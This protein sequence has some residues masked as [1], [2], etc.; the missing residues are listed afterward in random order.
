LNNR[1]KIRMYESGDGDGSVAGGTIVIPIDRSFTLH[2]ESADEAEKKLRKD[3]I[4]GKLVRGRVYQICP[5]IGNME[6]I[7]SVAICGE[8]NAKRVFLD[9]AKGLYSEFRRIRYP[10]AAA[11]QPQIVEELQPVGA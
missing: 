3:V 7:R 8:A 2:A 9:G 6:L 10:E 11:V 4:D 5:T 1:Y